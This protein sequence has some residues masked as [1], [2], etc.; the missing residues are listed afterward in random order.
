[1][2]IDSLIC[3]DSFYEEILSI[4]KLNTWILVR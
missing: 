2:G 3:N 4:K 1:M